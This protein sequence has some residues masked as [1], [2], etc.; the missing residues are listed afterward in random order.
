M[1]RLR[2]CPPVDGDACSKSKSN[3]LTQRKCLVCLFFCLF[4]C[5]LLHLTAHPTYQAEQL[6]LHFLFIFFLYPPPQSSILNRTMTVFL[7]ILL[8]GGVVAVLGPSALTPSVL[9]FC[10]LPSCFSFFGLLW[11]ALLCF[12][13]FLLCFFLY[14]LAFFH[15]L[16][17]CCKAA[18]IIRKV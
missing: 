6:D 13:C 5:P 15:S 4:V 12:L 17:A 11:F 14:C 10:K 18:T 1:W 2:Q 8:F 16:R 7:F 3:T 9:H